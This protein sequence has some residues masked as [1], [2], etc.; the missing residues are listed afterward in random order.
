[1]KYKIDVWQ[2]GCIIESYESDDIKEVAEWY[3]ENWSNAYS[4][5]LCAIEIYKQKADMIE[6]IPFNEALELGFY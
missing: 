5:G 4:Y 2:Y 1:M 3:K 6:D